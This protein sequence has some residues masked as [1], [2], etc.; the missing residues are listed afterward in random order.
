MSDFPIIRE[1]ILPTKELT[2]QR[3]LVTKYLAIAPRPMT[4]EERQAVSQIVASYATW[5][6]CYTANENGRITF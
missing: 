6:L 4:Q 5:A 1:C 3:E 2:P